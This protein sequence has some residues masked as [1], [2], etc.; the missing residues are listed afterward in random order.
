MLWLLVS[1][2][3]SYDD[4]HPHAERLYRLTER[5]QHQGLG[6]HSA[7]VPFPLAS[8]LQAEHPDLVEAHLRLFNFQAPSVG[9]AIDGKVFNEKRVF[10]ADSGF[11]DLFSWQLSEGEAGR[12]LASPGHVVLSA[13]AA[14]RFFGPGSALG[15]QLKLFGR[16]PL[17][18]SGVLAPD[19]PPSHLAPDVLVPMA[20]LRQI[21]YLPHLDQWTWNPCWSYVRLR[22]GV[23]P[24]QVEQALAQVLQTHFPTELRPHLTLGLQLVRDIHLHSALDYE[25]GPNADIKYVYVFVGMG[26]FILLIAGINYTNLTTAQATVRV[27]EVIVKKAIG[28]DRQGLF[29]EFVGESVFIGLTAVLLAL[30]MVELA[31]PYLNDLSGEPLRGTSLR[32]GSM[33]AGVLAAGVITGVLAGV[34]PAHY[35]ASFEVANVYHGRLLKLQSGRNYRSALVMLQFVISML[36]LVGTFVSK[37]QLAY[38]RN[39]RLGFDQ[40]HVVLVPITSG[41]L[42]VSYDEVRQ[43]LLA[44]SAVAAVTALEEIVGKKYQT[45]EFHT[46]RNQLG[47]FSFYPSIEVTYDF[48]QTFD[49]QLVAGRDFAQPNQQALTDSTANDWLNLTENDGNNAVLVNEAMVKHLGYPSAEAAIG[50]PFHRRDGNERIIGVVKDFHI[51]SLHSPVVPFVIDLAAFNIRGSFIKYLAVKLHRGQVDQ[52]LEHLQAVWQRFV[53]DQPF[54]YFFL[55]DNLANLYI[56]EQRL[57]EISTWFSVAALVIA[58]MGLFGLSSFVAERHRKEIG[59]RKAIGADALSVALYLGQRFVWLACLSLVVALPLGYLLAYA[60]LAGFPYRIS[61]AADIFGWSAL[62]ILGVTLVTVSFHAFKAAGQTP[63]EAIQM[64][65]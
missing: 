33:L 29:Y 57:G 61:L 18:V 40:N 44:D 52:G 25:I 63:V 35:L 27:R 5:V 36:L 23:A 11:F 17:R 26:I 9:L 59:I 14:A 37:R 39:A 20:T 16:H 8:T 15:K 21:G 54:D 4:H 3:L 46:D 31:S 51:S 2:E 60:W 43:N 64:R 10:F 30:V 47:E 42:I 7:S 28:A 1:H 48:L 19:Q 62:L 32:Q 55:R 38:L 12:T 41:R 65:P 22:P 6:E 45:H 13:A 58:C 24:A 34:Y 49:I 56:K 50:R 53:P